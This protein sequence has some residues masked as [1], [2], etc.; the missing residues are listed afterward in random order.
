MVNLLNFTVPCPF[1]CSVVWLSSGQ[2][3]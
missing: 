3:W 2:R 1:V